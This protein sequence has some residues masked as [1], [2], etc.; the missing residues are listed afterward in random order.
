MVEQDNSHPNI[1]ED[2]DSDIMLPPLN[3]PNKKNPKKK[4]L[5][6]DECIIIVYLI[7]VTYSSEYDVWIW[8]RT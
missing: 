5:L 6:R 8:R 4:G 7:F 2:S 3:K 1:L